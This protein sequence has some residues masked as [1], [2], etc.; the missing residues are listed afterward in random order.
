MVASANIDAPGVVRAIH[1]DYLRAGADVIISNNFY[2]TRERLR[3]IG[4]ADDWEEYTRRGG[5]LAV[6][7]RD[8]VNPEAYV[9]G[10]VSPPGDGDM[11]SQLEDQARILA[12]VGVD[13]ML[14]EYVGGGVRHEGGL[15]DCAI[16][17]EAFATAGLPVFLGISN[18]LDTG[19]MHGGESMQELRQTRSRAFRSPACS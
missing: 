7:T 14:P 12:S 8:N 13:F 11:R 16:A 18:L 10:G 17:A 1:E 9:G 3:T 15:E 6:D 4:A 5:E 2:T 19:T